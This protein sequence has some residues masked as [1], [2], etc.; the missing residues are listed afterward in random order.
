MNFPNIPIS[1]AL[2]N[3][4]IKIINYEINVEFFFI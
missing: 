4:I 1:C 3:T 2:K